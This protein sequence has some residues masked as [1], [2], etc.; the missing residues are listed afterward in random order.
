MKHISL[1]LALSF[2]LFPCAAASAQDAPPPDVPD[3]STERIGGGEQAERPRPRST[4][5]T[6]IPAGLLYASFDTSRDYSV[7][8]KELEQGIT[9][10]YGVADTNKNSRLSLV[11][12]AS[13]RELIL[14]SRDLL[15]GNTQFDKNFDSQIELGEF[16][17]VLTDLFHA[18][19]E[20]ENAQLEF[21][22]MTREA[23][24]TRGQGGES[25][26]RRERPQGG[27]GRG[28]RPQR[29]N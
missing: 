1:A 8:L 13:W 11:E 22:E 24:S 9:R 29:G 4:Q 5:R 19:D 6:L 7:S 26:Q 18:F 28:Q 21:K 17:A 3:F 25:G 16:S 14:G 2:L 23:R 15:P 12:L 27:Q 10:S 20:N